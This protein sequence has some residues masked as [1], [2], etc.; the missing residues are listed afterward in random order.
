MDNISEESYR[1]A[2]FLRQRLRDRLGSLTPNDEREI[3]DITAAAVG[4]TLRKESARLDRFHSNIAKE[5][6]W[7]AEARS[8]ELVDRVKSALDGIL[9][10]AA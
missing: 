6:V 4:D 2:A 1:L 3:D 10:D 7:D 5:L 8:R 9:E